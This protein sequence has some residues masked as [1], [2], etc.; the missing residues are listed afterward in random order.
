MK[1]CTIQP[2]PVQQGHE[3]QGH[4]QTCPVKT[5]PVKTLSNNVTC[6]ITKNDLKTKMEMT[7]L[8]FCFIKCL[9]S[10][11]KDAF[12]REY[13]SILN[14]DETQFKYYDIG[15]IKI[16][17]WLEIMSRIDL[18]YRYRVYRY[19]YW[20]ENTGVKDVQPIKESYKAMLVE[21]GSERIY[22]VNLLIDYHHISRIYLFR[23]S[24]FVNVNQWFWDKIIGSDNE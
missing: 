24:N 17:T 3:Q 10:A 19:A 6:S 12:I 5:Y 4:E 13:I 15:V 14:S 9:K 1:S 21:F 8:R 18:K 11:D 22:T 16:S 7:P 23:R 2:F 20:G